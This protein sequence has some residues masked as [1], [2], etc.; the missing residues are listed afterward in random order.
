MYND[1]NINNRVYL[2]YCD[3]GNYR[4]WVKESTTPEKFFSNFDK[5][6]NALKE[7]ATINYEFLNPTPSSELNE[8]QENEQKYYQ[9]FF[10]EVG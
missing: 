2:I 9:D 8:L 6:I 4:H 10:Q 7:L 3:I 1:T 5:L